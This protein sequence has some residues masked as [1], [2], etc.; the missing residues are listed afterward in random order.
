[1]KYKLLLS[2]IT[3]LALTFSA[4]IFGQKSNSSIKKIYLQG[5]IGAASRNGVSGEVGL[6]AIINNKWLASVSY[7]NIEA[8][9]KNL[10]SDYEG[11]IFIFFPIDLTPTVNTNV[12]NITAGK[13]F[14]T[15]KRTWI[16]TEG[17]ICFGTGET[18]SFK[19]TDPVF[20]IFG[21]TA[22]YVY[23]TEKKNLVGGVL[24]ADFNW[25]FAS[26]MGLGMNVYANFNSVQSPVGFQLKLMLGKMGV[27]KK[28]KS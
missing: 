22:N 20:Y 6:Q 8:N 13:Y 10:P 24:K 4:G 17:G 28:H 23:E 3:L 12:F 14:A 16:T 1:M 2:I 27:A 15:G 18:M 25:A 5:G 9:P 7:Q 21:E 19:R 26:F 11:E